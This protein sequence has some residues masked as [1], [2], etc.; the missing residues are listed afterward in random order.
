MADDRDSLLTG[1]SVSALSSNPYADQES[2]GSGAAAQRVLKQKQPRAGAKGSPDLDREA[3]LVDS[4]AR[5]SGVDGGEED[6]DHAEVSRENEMLAATFSPTA[7]YP[8]PQSAD[9][10]GF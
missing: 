5:L 2:F 4:T 10:L 6:N 1:S 9:I 3:L 8:T 7:Q